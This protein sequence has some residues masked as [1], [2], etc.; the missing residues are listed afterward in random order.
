MKNIIRT[1]FIAGAVLVGALVFAQVQVIPPGSGGGSSGSVTGGT[2]TNKVATAIASS[3]AAPTCTTV[4]SAYV[5]SSVYTTGNPP[6]ASGPNITQ[7]TY[8]SLPSTCTTNDMYIFTNTVYN[9]ARCSATNTWS[10]FLNGQLLNSPGPA[11]GW[12]AVNGSTALTIA[13]LVGMVQFSITN[14]SGLNWRFGDKSVPGSTPYTCTFAVRP[15]EQYTNS[16]AVGVYFYDG[17]KLYGIELLAQGNPLGVGSILILRV[18]K[19]TNV[20]TDGSTVASIILQTPSG[21]DYNYPGAFNYS[22]LPIYLQLK[23][24]GTNL[25]FLFSINNVNYTQLFQEAVGTYMTPTKF[26]VGGLSGSSTTNT[27]NLF[28]LGENGC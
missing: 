23:N 6:P 13:D 24:D 17:T 1:A 2:C 12:T 10:N 14:V 9:F 25:T 22:Q 18:E 3:T 16:N 28:L 8:A 5:D 26:G 11:S 19:I 7:G 27:V 20:T 4:T 15:E 21:S